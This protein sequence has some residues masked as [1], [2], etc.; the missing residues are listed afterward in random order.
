MLETS[1]PLVFYQYCGS[2]A[3]RAVSIALEFAVSVFKDR[4]IGDS[5]VAAMLADKGSELCQKSLV[6]HRILSKTLRIKFVTY[7]DTAHIYGI[8]TSISEFSDYGLYLRR[9]ELRQDLD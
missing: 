4:N 3:V 6:F 5:F 7:G 9:V 1:R 2:A 8:S